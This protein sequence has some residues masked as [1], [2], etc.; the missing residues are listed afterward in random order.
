M[1]GTLHLTGRYY[2]TIPITDTGCADGW[3]GT[4]SHF[5]LNGPRSRAAENGVSPRTASTPLPFLAARRY[6]RTE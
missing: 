3:E 4:D 2:R 6:R 5:P 1:P